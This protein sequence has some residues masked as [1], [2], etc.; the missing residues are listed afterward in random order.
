ML[1]FLATQAAAE[2]TT[3]VIL[4]LSLGLAAIITRRYLRKPSR[5]LH[6]WNLGVWTFVIG[7]ALEVLFAFGAYS[8]L[9]IC[10]YLFSV[11]ILVEL[12]A[13]GSMQLIKSDGKRNAY[14][15]FA[16]A[17]TLFLAYSLIGTNTGNILENYVVA[18]NPPN[19]VVI[20]SSLITFPAAAIL[21]IVAY[22]GYRARRDPRLLS[23][24]AG[25]V[26]VSVAGTLYIVQY[27]AFL[28][29]AELIGILALYYGFL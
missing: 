19:L 26:I 22:L 18:A 2:I 23:I 29:L 25:V 5:P 13:M 16:A 6:F 14:Y 27:P 20:A 15:A 28:Y 4:V 11:A 7:V 10:T 9:L 12:L 1:A 24:I 21:V 8:E 3:V 17:S